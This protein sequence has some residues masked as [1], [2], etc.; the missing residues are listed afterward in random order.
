MYGQTEKAVLLNEWSV[1][2]AGA[3]WL[4]RSRDVVAFSLL[5]LTIITTLSFILDSGQA[6]WHDQYLT[7]LHLKRVPGTSSFQRPFGPNTSPD[8]PTAQ[9]LNTEGRGQG[10]KWD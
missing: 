10:V 7:V 6:A 2:A 3:T 8:L 4:L 1:G 9:H 5:I